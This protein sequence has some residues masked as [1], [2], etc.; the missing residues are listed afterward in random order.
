MK[1]LMVIVCLL[2]ALSSLFAEQITVSEY[3]NDIHLINSSPNNLELEFTLGSFNREQI[4]INGSQWNTISL[5]KEAITLEAGLPQVPTVSRSVIIPGTAAMQLNVLNSEYID[6]AMPVA[7][8]KGNLTRDINPDS[9][10]YTFA[11]FYNSSDSYPAQIASLSEPFILR[12]YRGITVRLQPFVYYPA[13]GTLRV[14][15]KVLVSLQENGTDYRNAVTDTKTSYTSYFEETY[16]NMFLNFGQA[17]YPSLGEEGSILVIKHSMFDATLQPWVDWKRQIGFNV[18]VVDVTVAG[19]SA[20]NIKTYIQNYYNANS[21]LMFVQLFGDAPQIPTLSVGG[22]GSDPS[23][24]LVA[25]ND[26]YPDIYIGRFSATTVADMQTQIQRSVYYERDIAV[27]ASYLQNAMGIASNEGG[28]SQ[29]DMGESDIQHMN[30]IRTDLLGYGYTSVD[31]IYAPSASSSNVTTNL[32]QGRGFVNYVGHGSDTSWVT[33]G[34]SNTNVNSL[35]NSNMLPFI[36]SVACVNGNFVSQTCFAE[37][38]LRATNSTGEPTGAIAFY[39]STVN[40]GWNPPMRGQDEVTDLLIA[41]AKHRIGSL[42]FNGS[43]KMIEAYSSDGIDEFK[44]WTIFGDASLMVRTKNPTAITAT[45]NPV[46]FLG[47]ASFTIQTEPNAKVTLSNAGIIYGSAVADAAGSA[48]LSLNPVPI[49]PMDLTLTIFAFNKQTLIQTIQVLPSTGPY[50]MLDNLVFGANAPESGALVQISMELSNI[51]SETA[52]AVNITLSSTDPY[53]SILNP[54][55]SIG[56]LQIGNHLPYSSFSIQISSTIPDQHEVPL[57]FTFTDAAENIFEYERSFLVNA[58]AISWGNLSIDDSMGNNNGRVDA[59]ESIAFSIEISNTGHS[60]ASNISS[61]LMVNG[62][63]YLIEPL[64]PSADD[65]L[66]GEM[67]TLMYRVTFSSLTPAGT[68]IQLTVMSFF[69]DYMSVNTYSFVLGQDVEN[70]ESGLAALPWSFTGGTWTTSQASYNG[71][72]AAKS[73]QISHSTSTSMSIT[74]NILQ[75]GNITFWKKVSSEATYDKLTFHINGL[76]MSEWSGNNDNWSQVSL[77][78]SAGTNVFMWRYTK[79]GGGTVGS[80]CAWIDDIIFPSTNHVAGVPILSVNNHNLDFQDVAIGETLSMPLTISNLGTVS[81]M[82]T[83]S[84]AEPFFLSY[85]FTEPHLSQNY[86]LPAGESVTINVNFTPS[87]MTLYNGEL[88]ITSD[89]PETSIAIVV[90]TG[91]GGTVANSDLVSPL[92]TSLLG[93]F[94]NPFNPSTTI[95]F[96]LKEQSPVN[97]EIYNISGQKVRSLVKGIMPSG[98]HNIHWNG[99]DNSGKA[100][101]SGVYFIKMDSAKYTSTKKMILM[102]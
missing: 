45:Y 24:S 35:S 33:T 64:M 39:G 14:Y 30:I 93:N 71:T 22:G 2:F 29:G 31:Q 80:D 67:A 46:M 62:G 37:A 21:D 11:D 52:D 59:G 48:I 13:T 17:K 101:S 28:S 92:Q 57:V 102:K 69:G 58:P 68:T 8:S 84:S 98:T 75:S 90:L 77:P 96:S 36:V 66:A 49:E 10:P 3:Q 54:V 41:G 99:Q 89:D 12:D 16:R 15:T 86:Y 9:V 83:I 27:G 56:D 18:E 42:F 97:M 6:L 81:M 91:S 63:D 70:F 74:K 61:T 94:P 20:S 100:V 4:T 65:L 79:D 88:V 87:A 32:N 5:P 23:F 55:L 60:T 73:P 1:P 50:I 38:W 26:S 82:G 72:L 85:D 25:G 95:Q 47:M 43:S 19:P 34:F 78:V 40:Q 51:G 76:L 53:I 7:P 44:N